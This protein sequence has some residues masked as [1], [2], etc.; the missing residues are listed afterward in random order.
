VTFVDDYA[1]IPGELTA[2]LATAAT[3]RFDRVVAVFQPHRYSRTATLWPLFAD[4]FVDA[5]VVVI[6][7]VYAAG[8]T[9]RPG[10]SGELVVHAV[11]DAHPRARVVYLPRRDDLVRFLTSELRAGDVCLTLG[12]GDITT[13]GADVLAFWQGVREPTPGTDETVGVTAPQ[14]GSR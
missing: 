12:A 14:K 9:P 6:T 11:L 13:L 3:G 8:E 5:D 10:V 2:A 4:A 1:H 7:D